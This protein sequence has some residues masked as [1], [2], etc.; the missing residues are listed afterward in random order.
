[1]SIDKAFIPY[2][3]YWSTPFCRWQGSLAGE[4]AMSLAAASTR[5]FLEERTVPAESFDGIALGLTVFQRHSFYGAPR[6]AGM[7][8]LEGITGPTIAQACATSARMVASAALEVQAGA[9]KCLL[10]VA[11]DRTSNGPH[12][13]YPNPKGMGG[14]G[15]AEN[16]VVD[17]FG[18]DPWAKNAMIETAE[19][20]AAETGI[21]RA[22]Q[23]EMALLRYQQYADALADDRAFQRCY[24]MA[25]ELK[26]RGKVVGR[27]EADEG[28]H[29]TT[30][31]GLGK[32]RPVLEG[33]T[34]TFGSQTHPADGNAGMVLCEKEM[35]ERL[36]KDPQ[37]PIRVVSYGETRVNKGF[38][39]MAVVPAARDALARADLDIADCRAVK[40]HNPFALNDVYFCRE[41]KL[42]A[43]KVNRFG[44]PLIWGHPQAPTG[45]RA[46]IEL[47]EE[48]VA[49]G[50][51]FGLFSGCAAGD[52]AMAVVVKVGE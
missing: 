34:V 5:R 25:V 2:G 4:H 37:V 33:G 45:L 49:A 27:V 17:N 1:M 8:G 14:T 46:I 21:G 30:V 32:L 31:E 36:S 38:M 16:P 39:P 43:E 9:R 12:V 22:E 51:G 28:I 50:G 44:S 47:I 3:C 20:V 48:L 10:A 24:L 23:D 19:K 29:P 6:L 13:Y 18:I 41:M 40:T 11:C 26:K 7:A 15:Q 52:T 35:A 42:E